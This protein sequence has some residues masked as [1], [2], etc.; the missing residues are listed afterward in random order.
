[1]MK[2]SKIK[3]VSVC[4]IFVFL[5]LSVISL[6]LVLYISQFAF[7]FSYLPNALNEFCLYKLY[8]IFSYV[9][10]KLS[11]LFEKH[12]TFLLVILCVFSLL[13]SFSFLCFTYSIK[14]ISISKL[15]DYNFLDEKK[16]IKKYILS[17][18]IIAIAFLVSAILMSLNDFNLGAKIQLGIGVFEILMSLIY[19]IDYIQISSCYV[20]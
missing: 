5:L 20:K 8:P 6:F 1:M 14:S 19:L 13:F 4:N 15:G 16:R 11:T 7:E 17:F 3:V 12:E 2:K 18:F 10:E 9:P